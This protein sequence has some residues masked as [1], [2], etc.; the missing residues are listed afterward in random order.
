MGNLAG[1]NSGSP[2]GGGIYGDA[3]QPI[4]LIDSIVAKNTRDSATG[5]P[6][7]ASATFSTSSAFNLIGD[8][9]GQ[10]GLVAFGNNNLIGTDASPL[11]PLLGPLQNN[12]GPTLTMAPTPA[13]PAIDRGGP[14]PS[15]D[16]ANP[17]DQRGFPRISDIPDR[18]NAAGGDGRDLGAVEA[19]GPFRPTVLTVNSTAD[20]NPPAGSLTLRQAI[21]AADGTIPL[22][23]LPA[24]QVQA[25]ALYDL[26]IEFAVTGQIALNSPLPALQGQITI[27]GPGASQLTILG[28]PTTPDGVIHAGLDADVTVNA[29]TLDTDFTP[30]STGIAVDA[31]A[32]LAVDSIAVLHGSLPAT[33]QPYTGGIVATAGGTSVAIERSTFNDLFG[34]AVTSL[35]GTLS[36]DESTF[37]GDTSFNYGGAIDSG[38]SAAGIGGVLT[39]TRSYFNNDFAN[40]V[41]GAIAALGGSSATISDST[42][43]DNAGTSLG[44][45]I[46]GRCSARTPTPSAP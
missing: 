18:L 32:A 39:V 46:S 30:G 31:G 7:D 15:T 11:D 1:I 40:I 35:G 43:V 25:G 34:S 14:S 45:A 19:Q 44:G 17:N 29:V 24:G 42:F 41:G 8:G 3:G 5:S 33:N 9:T 20:A 23:S 2:L 4:T 6:D 22:S 13:S 16:T 27:Q 37:V 26:V 28:N 10:A 38:A 12:G 21:E 36:V